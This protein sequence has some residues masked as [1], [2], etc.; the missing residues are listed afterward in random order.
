M[1]FV[2]LILAYF[3]SALGIAV[4]HFSPRLLLGDTMCFSSITWLLGGVLAPPMLCQKAEG[5]H[6]LSL[7]LQWLLGAIAM[8][9]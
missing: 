3:F 5:K 6:C 8:P 9:V 2:L 4:L 1:L 7:C